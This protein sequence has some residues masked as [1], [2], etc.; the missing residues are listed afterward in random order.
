MNHTKAP[1]NDKK[2]RQALAY[3]VDKEGIAKNLL[4][5]LV[6]PAWQL[7]SPLSWAYNPNVVKHKF[8]QA[9]AKQLLDEAGW[10]PGADGIR[11]KDGNKLSFEIMNIAGEQERVQILSF[12]QRQWKEIGVDA[13]IK[14]ADVATM[15]GNALPK[16]TYEMAYSYT[17]RQADPDISGWY[18]S[19]NKNPQ[20]NYAGY[21]NPD[22]DKMLTDA[23]QTVD[24]N[25]R[26]DLYFKAQEIVADDV[27]YLFLFWLTNHTVLNKRVQ[28]YKPAPAYCEFWNADEW[29]LDK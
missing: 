8:D 26:K 11:E 13:K 23:L 18:L 20:Y 22:V 4:K 29:W 27:V 5:G 6:E 15:W 2:V 24:Q 25:K 9:K 14:M 10:K 21:S 1:F 12:I 3:G 7:V 28:G 19:P 16:R 17:G